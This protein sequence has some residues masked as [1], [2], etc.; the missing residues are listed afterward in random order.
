[1]LLQTNSYIVPKESRA[2]HARLLRR[3]RHAL[4]QIGCPDFEVY[5]QVSTDWSGSDG[6]GRYVQIMRFR[7][8]LHQN[9]VQASERTDPVAQELIR[10][11]CALINFPYQ[12]QQGLFAVGF[13]TSVL[14]V[15]PSQE[16]AE[17]QQAA[18]IPEPVMPEPPVASNLDT[19][20]AED[21]AV[22]LEALAESTYVPE[23][24]LPPIAI[25]D[26][27]VA[28]GHKSAA[29]IP[30][31]QS[32]GLH[33]TESAAATS[34]ETDWA[35]VL[36]EPLALDEEPEGEVNAHPGN[37]ARHDEPIHKNSLENEAMGDED[38]ILIEDFDAVSDE[39]AGR[40]LDDDA[41]LDALAEGSDLAAP[42]ENGNRQHAGHQSGSL[43]DEHEHPPQE[44]HGSIAR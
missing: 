36:N 4:A 33:D 10:E 23:T 30:S 20:P 24:P 6:N 21:E 29:E 9:Q 26:P 5:E 37:S 14:P 34:P 35:E 44:Q 32:D 38:G 12:Q 8:K 25:P 3:F 17:H 39:P 40:V 16:S 19:L 41:A 13:Y 22:D 18:A 15:G 42:G 1:M 31:S 11:F 7:D 27:S 2:E 43:P 28:D